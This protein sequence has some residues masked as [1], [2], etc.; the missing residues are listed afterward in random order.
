VI[1]PRATRLVRVQD[2]RSF[3][4]AI[5]AL[6]C[7]GDPFAV[8]DRVIV[9]PTRAAGAHLT[10]AIEDRLLASRAAVVLPQLTTRDH[11]YERLADRLPIRPRV[12]DPFER[13]ALLG[14]ACNA[15]M[16]D[17][18]IP[19]FRLRPGLVAEV[20]KFYDDLRR[21][22]N[23]VASFETRALR[24]LEPGAEIDRG[25]E[26]LVHQTR[27]LV[28]AFQLFEKACEA[29]GAYDEHRLRDLLRHTGAERPWRHVIVT[30]RDRAA[31]PHGLW[32]CDLDLLAR[33]PG[34]TRLDFVVT[35][36]CL[37]GTLHERM[38][39]LFPGV[40]EMRW[41]ADE[42]RTEPMLIVPARTGVAHVSRDREEEVTDFARRVRA[43]ARRPDAPS[44]DRIA[45]VVRRPL[46]YVYVAREVL[47]SAA[48]PCQMFDALPLAAEPYAAALD[49][50]FACVSGNFARTPL[51]ALLRSPQLHFA[52]VAANLEGGPSEAL[53]ARDLSYLDR[54]LSEAGYLSG[55]EGLDAI[56]AN[57]RN[58]TRRPSRAVLVGEIAAEVVRELLPLQAT[59]SVA[60]HLDTLLA[61]L[62]R[63]GSVPGPD[64]PLRA[65]QLRARAAILAALAAIRAA[66]A[67]YDTRPRGFEEVAAMVRR[68]VEG[69]TFA[70]RAGESGVH[71]V[72]AESAPY[73]DFE[74]V[75]L[76][77]L[78]E[79][80]W[81]DRPR[82]S[83]FYSSAVLRE[84]GWPPDQE[85][86]DG[87]RNAFVDLLRLPAK[88]LVVS[89]FTLEDDAIVASSSFLDAVE[90]SGLEAIEDAAPTDTR[91]FEWEALGIEPPHLERLDATAA[92][93]ARFRIE[94]PPRTDRYRGATAG[95]AAASFAV[96]A[97][98]RYQDCPFKFFAAD[99]LRLEEAPEDEP[100][101]S[102][103]ARGRFIHEVFQQFFGR[104]GART[105]TPETLDEARALFRDVAEK[106]LEKLPPAEASLER[107]R[108]FGSAIA[109]G[110]GDVVL[111]IEAARPVAV[112]ERLLE[113]PLNG[114]FT[115]GSS[116]R[117]APIRGVAD[118][119]DIL[120][121]RRLRV[122][123]YK[124][125]SAPQPKRA[126]QV[127]VYAMAAAERLAGR[128]GQPW[129]VDEAA[130]VALSGKRPLVPI[131][132]AGATDSAAVLNA[133]GD[134]V[135]AILDSIA[136]GEFPPRPHD[137]IICGWCAYSSVCRKDYVGDE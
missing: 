9:V 20:L 53:T 69:Q 97:L 47:R 2:L 58:D 73:G 112:K 78:I 44:L 3:R 67:A 64:D 34:L 122:I 104:W 18:M 19:P 35:D 52:Q 91:V 59:A 121:G 62:E 6:A 74:E 105:I 23:D 14:A 39:R 107:T 32:N 17:G 93:W 132:K 79:A 24:V 37:A 125:G 12:L 113:H 43:T 120:D 117:R 84:L 61:F 56:I 103:R 133:A 123:D 51:V 128:D 13:E 8:R 7:D 127:P 21:H 25:A 27:F 46:P 28:H 95:H 29:T 82:P 70:P 100:T 109:M 63:H 72:D 15:A 40:E 102:P 57:W 131:L 26:R 96:S 83:I 90:T 119:I 114:D 71:L 98:E 80:E 89:T 49:L 33:L 1:T 75:Q 38:H 42:P 5:T 81:P 41:A 106:Q 124:A 55:L 65:R 31:D 134:R 88:R 30:V 45:L 136:R 16:A 36:T 10:R 115:L 94:A 11:L 86:V 4:D 87:A 118:R 66:H 130:Y 126:L 60:T 76:G 137:P 50:V 77:G 99:V 101:L 85:R 54:D 48:V 22:E 68:W 135:F 129:S 116:G 92:A 111:G 110:I 108:L